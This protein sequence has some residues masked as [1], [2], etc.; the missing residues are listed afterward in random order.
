MNNGRESL[1]PYIEILVSGRRVKRKIT[2]AE[3][4]DDTVYKAE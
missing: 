4:M 3:A 2:S 1:R